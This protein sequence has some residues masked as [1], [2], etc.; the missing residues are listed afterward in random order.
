MARVSLASP[1]EVALATHYYLQFPFLDLQNG[2][3]T[4]W[5]IKMRGLPSFGGPAVERSIA[6]WR[7]PM[8]WQEGSMLKCHLESPV[9][10]EWA[11]SSR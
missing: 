7:A 4:I 9:L 10:S 3:C 11:V 1:K 2:L 8:K 5:Y 6:G